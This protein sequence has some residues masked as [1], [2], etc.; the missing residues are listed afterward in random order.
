MAVAGFVCG[1]VGMILA[2]IGVC[3]FIGGPLAI[4]GVVLSV[5]GRNQARERGAPQGLATAGLVTG[6]IGTIA[7]LIWLI[8][9]ITADDSDFDS[10]FDFDTSIALPLMFVGAKLS[11]LTRRGD[12][13]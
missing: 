11:R 1:L 2:V 6:I 8:V 10:D 4:V 13:N 5:V 7:G 12:Q 3:F 9:A